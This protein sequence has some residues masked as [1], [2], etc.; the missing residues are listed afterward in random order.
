MLA[1]NLSPTLSLS[2]GSL[3]LADFFATEL[4][5]AACKASN[6]EAQPAF[7]LR[8]LS[9]PWKIEKLLDGGMI[10]PKVLCL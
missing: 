2:H 3:G 10:V 1:S 7:T 6:A 5:G 4:E 8:S 9:V